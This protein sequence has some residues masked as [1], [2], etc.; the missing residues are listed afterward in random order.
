MTRRPARWWL[1]WTLATA[2]AGLYLICYRSDHAILGL[3]SLG[4]P[5]PPGCYACVASGRLFV[6]AECETVGFVIEPGPVW[7]GVELPR[8]EGGRVWRLTLPLWTVA[9]PLAAA[10]LWAWLPRDRPPP[11]GCAKCGY[12]R[13]GLGEGARCPECGSQAA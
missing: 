13:A 4:L 12:D 11:G 8:W 2:A 5:S 9:V 1:R 3:P 10:T 7:R 6:Q